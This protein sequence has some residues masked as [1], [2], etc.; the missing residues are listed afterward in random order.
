[1]AKMTNCA[2]CGKE[3]KKGFFGG[4]DYL[5]DTGAGL[6]TC[7]EDCLDKYRG[8]EKRHRKRFEAKM[9]NLKKAGKR[10]VSKQELASM[11]MTYLQEEEDQMRKG[12]ALF[13]MDV[14]GCFILG[15][16]GHFAVREQKI[17]FGNSD[18][19]AK[20]MVKTL[21]KAGDYDS[22]F[23]DKEDVTK[24]EF[25]S[26]GIGDPLTLF[27]TAYSYEIRLNDEKVMTYKPCI[28]RMAVL[29]TGIFKR[30]SANKKMYRL[31]ETFKQYI[32]SD[33]PVVKVK[34]FR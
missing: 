2:F 10:K 5:I 24:L 11:Y 26:T 27:S 22:L 18:V 6:L 13:P 33:L 12:G 1:M 17:G 7:C 30:R 29:G 23:F 8:D 16:D 9:E 28:T 3:L 32:G 19:S 20:D 31:M 14:T 21:N 34:K 15:G 25:R 4:D